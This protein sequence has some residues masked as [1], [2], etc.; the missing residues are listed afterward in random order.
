M[1][2]LQTIAGAAVQPIVYRFH[3]L[4]PEAAYRL[5]VNGKPVKIIR[6]DAGGNL[7]I[8]RPA[9]GGLQ[10]IDISFFHYNF[11]VQGF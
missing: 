8:R 4:T 3:Q 6:S 1:E 11:Q 2:W 10:R 5:S 7:V 9:T